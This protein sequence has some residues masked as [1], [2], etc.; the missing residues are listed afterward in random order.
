MSAAIRARDGLRELSGERIGNEMRR[1]VLAPRAAE[2]AAAMQEAGILPIVLAG[3]GYLAAF[4][5]LEA[6][7][8]AAGIRPDLAVRL[9]ALA[10]RIPED[11]LRIT[12][13]LR[14]SNAERDRIVA[15]LA[16]RRDMTTLPDTRTARRLA[17]VHGNA[18]AG[19]ARLAFAAGT[20]AHE[21]GWQALQS[22]AAPPR[23]P[24]SGKDIIESSRI[25]RGPE[26]GVLLRSLEA[27]WI[28]QDFTPDEAALRQRLQQIVAATQ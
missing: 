18:F 17:Y 2:T 1:L 12:E 13:L 10:C 21:A 8:A 4:A 24:L 6:F 16:V 9:A 14:L 27:W 15:V 28:D 23:F 25:S 5:R 3:I 11:A 22:L 19:G 20:G 7:E 26:V